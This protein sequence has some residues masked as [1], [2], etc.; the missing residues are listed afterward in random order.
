MPLDLAAVDR[1]T[2]ARPPLT[3][4]ICQ[5]RYDTTPAASDARKLQDLRSAIGGDVAFPSVEEIKQGEL[6]IQFGPGMSPAASQ[7]TT[8]GRGWR[9]RSADGTRVVALLPTWVTLEMFAYPGWDEGF[10]PML[11]SLIQAANDIVEPTF[12]QR[13]GL[14]Y[15]NQIRTPEDVR[16]AE[17]WAG[18][19]DPT[20]LSVAAHPEI[21]PHVHLTRQQTVLE[22][23]DGV[24]C[25]V[26]HGFGP[27]DDRGGALTYVLDLD[28]YR[29]GM[30]DFDP[31][32]IC[33]TVTEF[34]LIA[35]RLFQLATTPELREVLGR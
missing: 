17:G 35:L 29:E 15:I 14:R 26:N 23:G 34:N 4:V 6:S 9:L 27:D 18:F 20:F 3:S 22:L 1:S 32:L 10:F 25:N 33:A 8:V 21:G 13:L 16:S 19:I 30:R 11:E 24:A 5:V 31:Q 28:V 2:L 12:E 7:Q